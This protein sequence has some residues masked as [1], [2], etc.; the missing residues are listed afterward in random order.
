MKK[1]AFCLSLCLILIASISITGTAWAQECEIEPMEGRIIID[2]GYEPPGLCSP[3]ELPDVNC[4][5]QL[6]PVDVTPSIPAGTYDITLQSYDEHSSKPGQEQ[7]NESYFLEL[8]NAAG[9]MIVATNAIE[10]LPN[11]NDN[12]IQL[13]NTN[14]AVGG[15]ID[16]LKP[17]HSCDGSKNCDD[18][19]NSIVPVCV[20]LDLIQEGTGR[21]TGGGHLITE[22]GFRVSLGLTIHCD[23]LLSNNLEV[24][25]PDNKFHMTEHELTVDCLD[26]PD[27]MQHPPSA[28]LDTLIGVGTGRYNGQDGFTIEFTLIDD[29]EPGRKDM[30]SLLIYETANPSNVVLNVPLQEMDGG[31]LQAHYDQP[32][33]IK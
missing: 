33:K 31:N 32:H 29:G 26:S 27:I 10:D 7:L 16:S 5:G 2:F 12:L 9:D 30:A 18:S 4:L 22:E 28:P 13:V 25:W 14:L 17:I 20:A 19:P 8:R 15:D 23:L 3:I 6:D 1:Y 24:N 11:E 21:F